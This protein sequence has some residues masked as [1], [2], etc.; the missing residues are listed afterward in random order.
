[1][2]LIVY[3]KFFFI[4]L[5]HFFLKLLK[6]SLIYLL[7]FFSSILYL[8]REICFTNPWYLIEVWTDCG[9]HLLFMKFIEIQ[10]ISNEMC[11]IVNLISNHVFPNII[12]NIRAIR[13]PTQKFS[14]EFSPCTNM[15]CERKLNS[16]VGQLKARIRIG[17]TSWMQN[18][19]IHNNNN[20]KN[21]NLNPCIPNLGS[22]NSINW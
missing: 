12:F 22:L 1:M 21:N 13:Y 18:G 19:Y 14:N 11:W 9:S 16:V 7:S 3:S 10:V 5:L 20:N 4:S 17:T 6:E 8:L 15:K 2:H